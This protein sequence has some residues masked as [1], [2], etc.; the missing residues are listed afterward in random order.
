MQF[1]EKPNPVTKRRIK[2][3][4]KISSGVNSSHF[5]NS[6]EFSTSNIKESSIPNNF[7]PSQFNSQESSGTFGL[8]GLC[9]D[10]DTTYF[11]QDMCNICLIKPKDGFFNHKKTSHNYSCYNCSKRVWRQTG[12][13]PICNSKI[14]CVTKGIVV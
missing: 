4:N 6:Q 7:E 8:S 12:K 2:R 5:T 9:L 1:V 14:M 11:A 3:L 10:K 13:C